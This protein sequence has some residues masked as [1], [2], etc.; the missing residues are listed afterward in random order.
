MANATRGATRVLAS[1][2]LYH[3]RPIAPTR[4]LALGTF[5]LPVD[6]PPGAGP[7]LLGGIVARSAA[8]LDEELREDLD[9]LIVQLDSGMRIVQ[10]RLRHRLQTDPVGLL[11]SEHRLLADGTGVRFDFTDQGTALVH[12]LGAAYAA[13][14]L[15]GGARPAAFGL[16]R[17]ALRWTGAL[18]SVLIAHLAGGSGTAAWAAVGQDPRG[19]ALSVLGFDDGDLVPTPT[20]VRRRFR[21]ALRE[22]HPDHGAAEE[23]AADRIAAITEARRLLGG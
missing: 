15:A 22:A 17:R 7:I 10:P 11:R 3:S 23:G 8:A 2:S 13:A 6:P 19:W 5:D 14:R 21:I 18:D 20:Q 1:L 16:L 12:A 9:L 4:R